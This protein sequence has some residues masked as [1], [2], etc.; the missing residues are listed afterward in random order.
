MNYA[1]SILNGK[2]SSAKQLSD[3]DSVS[4][5]AYVNHYEY[6]QPK[7][8]KVFKKSKRYYHSP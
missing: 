5:N 7:N 8:T 3:A 6:I 2:Y 4:M 1:N